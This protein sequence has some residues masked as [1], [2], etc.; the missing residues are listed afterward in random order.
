[1]SNLSGFEIMWNSYPLWD[2]KRT[3]QYIFLDS[4]K[5]PEHT[6]N[7]ANTGIPNT[8]VIKICY[9][10]NCTVNPIRPIKLGFKYLTGINGLFIL[11]CTEMNSYLVARYG[12]PNI[13]TG[14]NDAK[15]K[16]KGR[17]GI[18]YFKISGWDDATGH[19]DLWN[20]S[21][22]KRGDYFKHPGLKNVCLWEVE[23]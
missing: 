14:K 5:T 11:K 23:D 1:M 16:L 7:W 8:C 20:G 19:F 3:V 15:Q 10:L 6:K 17:R 22:V 12:Q 4:D 9:V 18:I 2:V 13:T 21:R